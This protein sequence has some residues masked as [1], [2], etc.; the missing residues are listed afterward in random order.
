MWVWLHLGPYAMQAVLSQSITYSVC[1]ALEWDRL[2][3]GPV[4]ECKLDCGGQEGHTERLW[5]GCL[6]WRESQVERL[7]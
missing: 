3:P 7:P 4:E 5:R 2:L 6:T 1:Q